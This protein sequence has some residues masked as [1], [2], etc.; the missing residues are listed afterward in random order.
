MQIASWNVNSLRV[1][2]EQVLDWLKT[3]PVDVLGLQ[4]TKLPDAE[5]PRAAIEQAGYQVSFSGQKTYNGVALLT[6]EP[7]SDVLFDLPGMD[8][9]PQRRFLAATLDDVRIFNLYVPNG[10]SPDSDKFQYKLTW[11]ACLR[12]TLAAALKRNDKIAVMGDFNIAPG[13]ADVHD[14]KAWAGKIH[15]SQPE[16]NALQKIF[17]LGF[18]DSFRL[19]EQEAELY[20]WWDY[21]M[22]AFRRNRGLRIDLVLA[23]EQ[24]ARQCR[25]SVID[26]GPRRAERPSDHAPVIADFEPRKSTNLP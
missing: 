5:F 2:L 19:F 13:D 15:C 6:R 14:P 23:S 16:R 9:D 10:Q 12:D 18:Q 3:N 22:A 11:L 4:E 26:R 21:R 25:S 20:S 8:D 1:R 24:L 7:V 17:E